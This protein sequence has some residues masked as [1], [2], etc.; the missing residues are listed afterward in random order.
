M[1]IPDDIVRVS[2]SDQYFDLRGLS[3]YSS[4]GK[5]TLRYHILRNNLPTFKIPGRGGRVGKILVRKSEFDQWL[6]G[7][8]GN[9]F[10]DIEAA[11][12]EAV[13]ALSD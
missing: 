13:R 3:A 5:S 7:F 10:F 8:R 1:I 12:E 2:L 11:A 9:D 4:L 6:E